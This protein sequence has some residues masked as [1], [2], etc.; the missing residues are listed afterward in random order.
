MVVQGI[1]CRIGLRMYKPIRERRHRGPEP[2]SGAAG[3]EIG[4]TEEATTGPSPSGSASRRWL[5][6]DRWGLDA[7]ALGFSRWGALPPAPAPEPPHRRCPS[8]LS[9][10]SISGLP[11]EAWVKPSGIRPV[12]CDRFWA[13]T[14]LSACHRL[15]KSTPKV[16]PCHQVTKSS[17]NH[18][19][20]YNTFPNL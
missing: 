5:L 1:P 10:R 8:L 3:E 19:T 17:M 2:G 18:E 14:T 20:R 6:A 16:P 9:R 4:A 13:F 7:G 12:R 15:E 11:G